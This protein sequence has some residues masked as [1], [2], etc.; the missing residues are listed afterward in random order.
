MRH[1]TQ[2]ATNKEGPVAMQRQGGWICKVGYWY[3]C[4][5]RHSQGTCQFVA[6][7]AAVAAEPEHQR[8]AAPHVA[9]HGAPTRARAGPAPARGDDAMLLVVMLLSGFAVA[10]AP[11]RSLPAAAAATP[12]PA[13]PEE[14]RTAWV[15]NK[16]LADEQMQNITAADLDKR[17][18]MLSCDIHNLVT[19]NSN[20][21]HTGNPA[22]HCL[23]TVRAYLQRWC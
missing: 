13:P 21:M 23:H 10:A 7:A 11:P 15:R 18:E 5:M 19:L 22:P 14:M 9:R 16:A 6:A 3:P 20:R 1:A 12:P 4:D 2:L 8:R 17:L